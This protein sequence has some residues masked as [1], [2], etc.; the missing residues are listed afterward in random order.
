[1]T[2]SLGTCYL[3][4]A[5]VPLALMDVSECAERMIFGMD[6]EVVREHE[7]IHV[8][9]FSEQTYLLMFWSSLPESELDMYWPFPYRPMLIG[10]GKKPHASL[11]PYDAVF[12]H[13]HPRD[14][15]CGGI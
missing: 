6:V 1:M 2:D 9:P 3:A 10:F 13:L 15:P 12:F 8:Y 4:G 14:Y 5:D 11:R 7:A